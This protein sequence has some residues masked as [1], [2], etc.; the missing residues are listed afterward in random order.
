MK[1]KFILLSIVS[2]LL[3]CN[4]S[5]AQTWIPV[6]SKTHG[7]PVTMK[8]LKDDAS[9]Y[10]IEITIN[11][12]LDQQIDV[13][14]GS[15]HRISIGMSGSLMNSGEPLLPI[16]SQLIA[17]PEG[18]IAKSSV[19]EK[20]WTDVEI[21]SIL[22]AQIPP[23]GSKRV[24]SF[25][26]K[27]NAYTKPFIPTIVNQCEEQVWC[28]IKN[29]VVSICP[30]RYYPI[31]NRLSVLSKFILNIDFIPTDNQGQ[32]I[33][34]MSYE[35]C[36]DLTLF[37]NTIFFSPNRTQNTSLNNNTYL[38]I[39]GDIPGI[40]GSRQLKDFMR[41][42][43]L[44][45][46][47]TRVV[48]LSS[49]LSTSSYSQDE[50]KEYI[51]DEV[52][53]GGFVLLVGDNTKIPMASIPSFYYNYQTLYGDYWYGCDIGT[54]TWEADIAVGRFSVT[55]LWEFENMVRKTINYESINP[56]T[57]NTLLVAHKEDPTS[58]Y[59]YQHWCERIRNTNYIEPMTFV[60]AY[61]AEG[62]TNADVINFLNSG[63]PIVC[64]LG[65]GFSNFWG[66]VGS[67]YGLPDPTGGWNSAGESFFSSEA[68]NLND[69][70]RAVIFSSASNTA[71]ISISG[72]MLETFTRN[73]YGAPAFVGAATDGI[74]FDEYNEVYSK[75]LFE[76]LL[77]SGEYQL[78]DI[79]NKAHIS[80]MSYEGGN[81]LVLDH[82][83]SSVCGGDPALELWTDTICSF[84]NVDLIEG[85]NSI[86]IVTSQY[87]GDYNVCVASED[88]NLIG[89]YPVMASNTCT[90][91][92]PIGNFYISIIKHNYI[93]HIIK[94]D[95][96]TDAIQNENISIDSYYHYTPIGLGDGVSLDVPD[97]PVILKGGSK[98]II[99]NGTGGVFFIEG[100]ECEKGGIL[101]VK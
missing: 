77:C 10:Q 83:F 99:Q 33:E 9:S 67:N 60:T 18:T 56:L 16:I 5:L 64:Y 35:E 31:E 75:I 100:F 28:D 58:Y 14:Q 59:G 78:A 62:A 81:S 27:E 26:K 94:Y 74:N 101:E 97:G 30:F 17:I 39:V 80:C 68:A 69:S 19:V 70:A 66:G 71:N 84:G 47:N 34:S 11:G 24:S 42:K 65:F 72:N 46:F 2:F 13:K 44:K 61:G 21:G 55:S 15:F 76:K 38:I 50:V 88:G 12:I 40:I 36:K 73:Y 43:S 23:K 7:E 91:P 86:T 87:N 57:L 49:I 4:K 92:R 32:E 45:G 3:I 37:D 51:R 95:V 20:Q 79:T 29:V 63:V 8:I 89:V 93:P 25:Y 6:G 82:S 96:Y 41:W 48:S 1:I 52:G 90:F 98:L 53:S 85:S 54:N 22:P